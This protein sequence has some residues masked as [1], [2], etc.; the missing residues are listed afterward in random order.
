MI[1]DIKLVDLQRQ[2]QGIRKEVLVAVDATL[3]GMEL[4]LGPNVRAFERE[5]ADYCGSAEAIGVG[6]GTDALYLALRACDIGPGDEVITVANTFIATVEAIVMAGAKPV[7]VD[8]EAETATMDPQQVITAITPHTRALMPVHLYGQATDMAPLLTIAQ[9]H[10]LRV[11]E[12]A[13][14]AQGARYH[15]CPVGSLGDIGAFSLYYSKNLGGYGEAGIV[16]TND[17]DI[18]ER[19]RMLRD[20]GSRQ[21][22]H[23]ELIGMNSRLDELQAAILRIK[24]RRLEEWNEQR[25]I[26]AQVY[27]A[28]LGGIVETPLE[29]HDSTH[30]YYVYVI[31]TD[32][33]DA[34][35]D[36]LAAQ[37][38]QSGIHYPIPL[39][40]QPACAEFACPKGSLPV[41]ERLAGRI[42]SLPMFP[43]LTVDEIDHICTCIAQQVPL[44][45]QTTE[46][47]A[48]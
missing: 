21:R 15:G 41:T 24:L 18:A 3:S 39:H 45:A 7:F 25:R 20:H 14:Q 38:I 1:E 31:Q 2:Y 6:S 33:R 9:E 5:F 32:D 35:R 30:V 17:P 4:F 28:R 11:I 19:L 40:L 29:R 44:T 46:H 42:L 26:H 10:R 34:L 47:A 23:H 36:A 8:V 48:Y 12:D 43:E 22:Y 27:T 13:S 37:G 16:T